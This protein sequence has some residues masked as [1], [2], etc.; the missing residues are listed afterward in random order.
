MSIINFT[1][2]V[3]LRDDVDAI[4]YV[5]SS[6]TSFREEYLILKSF[7]PTEVEMSLTHRGRK[8]SAT[9]MVEFLIM[10]GYIRPFRIQ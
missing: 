10:Q 1:G 9:A 5:T 4:F 7:N 8:P 3:V 6:N 2:D